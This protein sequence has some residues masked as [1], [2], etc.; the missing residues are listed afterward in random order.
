MVL[1]PKALPL[2][3]G[4]PSRLAT[5]SVSLSRWAMVTELASALRLALPKVSVSAPGL[6]SESALELVPESALELVPESDSELVLES[7]PVSEP[8]PAW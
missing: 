8:A 2:A 7:A 1:A 4:L 3:M 5:A 6:V